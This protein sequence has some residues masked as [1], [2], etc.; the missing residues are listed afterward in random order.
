MNLFNCRNFDYD[1]TDIIE[2]NV[3]FGITVSRYFFINLLVINKR[4]MFFS[5][6]GRIRQ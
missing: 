4:R 3:F 1:Y 6:E 2:I 5:W